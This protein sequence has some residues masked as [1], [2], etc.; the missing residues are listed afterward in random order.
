VAQEDLVVAVVVATEVIIQ[1]A[2][3]AQESF[4]FSTRMEL[5]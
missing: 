2:Q 5:L 3:A 4:I 1:A